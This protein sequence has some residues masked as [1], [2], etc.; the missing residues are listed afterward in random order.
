V[1]AAHGAQGLS[2]GMR[3]MISRLGGAA[4][5]WPDG[6]APPVRASRQ[7]RRVGALRGAAAQQ[8]AATGGAGAA[9][10]RL[11]A[12]RQPGA[13]GRHDPSAWAWH[14]GPYSA[15]RR[16]LAAKRVSVDLSLVCEREAPR[17]LWLDAGSGAR[18]DAAVMLTAKRIL[19]IKFYLIKR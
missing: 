5:G 12:G 18:L 8:R 2:G 19:L 4:S 9:A 7:P 6:R 15:R 13:R 14:P 10:R 16:G 11:S 17:P 3:T 1:Q